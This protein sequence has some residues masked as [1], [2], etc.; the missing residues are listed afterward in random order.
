MK[1]ENYVPFS[2][3]DRLEEIREMEKS[4]FDLLI[5]G[6]GATGCGIALDAATRGLKVALIEK[7]DF[8]SGTS[9]KSTKLIHGGLRYLKQLDIALVRETGTERAVVHRLAP[10]LVLPEKMLLPLIKGGTYGKWSTSFGLMIYDI[11][12][13]VDRTD[14]RKMLSKKATLT[15]EPLLNEETV[16][17]SGFYA[18]YR[19]D[20]ARLTIEL[21][22]MAHQYGAKAI[23]YCELVDFLY[24]DGRIVGAQCKNQLDAKHFSIKAT[25]I[26]SAGGPW[27]DQVRQ[28][29]GSLSGK[30]LH[31]TKG[32]H[33]VVPHEKLPLQHSIYFDVPDGRMIFAIPRGKVTYIGTTDTNY[34]GRLDRVVVTKTDANYLLEAVNNA[35]PAIHLTIDDISSNW[36][37]LRPLIHEDGKDPSELSRKDEIFIS[38]SGLISI[39]GGKLTGYRRMAQRIV[40]LVAKEIMAESKQ[41]FDACKT[42]KI[43]LTPNTFSNA[44]AV[45]AYIQTLEKK[46]P[47]LGLT[48]YEAWYLTTVY[49]MQL[50]AILTKMK[51]FSSDRPSTALARAEAWFTVHFEKVASA[52]DFFV[53]RTG[54]L[55]FDIESIKEVRTMVM[56]DLQAYLNWDSDRLAKEEAILDALLYDATH[57]YEEELS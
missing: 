7:G 37:G 51:E 10:H 44:K 12:A 30:R 4:T 25:K 46:M 36:A 21:I 22:K 35:F 29:D 54:R 40:D 32:V 41:S 2:A 52:S 16:K 9:S 24:D 26:V 14:R 27:V 50:E 47:A 20:D 34:K 15:L 38:A 43:N 31:L 42:K 1:L 3:A 18:E 39:A 23:N 56:K 11:L 17:G 45:Q 57:Y 53:R 5:I 13:G 49:G 19:T 8:A 48:A 28:M 33:I 6:G 55:Y